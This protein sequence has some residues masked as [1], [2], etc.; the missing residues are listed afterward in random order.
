[1]V[2]RQHWCP[3]CCLLIVLLVLLDRLFDWFMVTAPEMRLAHLTIGRERSYAWAL[4]LALNVHTSC[5]MIG[6]SS[7]FVLLFN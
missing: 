7:V 3:C 6:F 4:R 5:C 2:F 1:M